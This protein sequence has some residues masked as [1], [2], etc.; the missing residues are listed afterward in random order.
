MQV[1]EVGEKWGLSVA[2]GQRCAVE[3]KLVPEGPV[4]QGAG[5]QVT[6]S[7]LQVRKDLLWLPGEGMEGKAL[8]RCH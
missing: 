5:G 2:G 7:E 3:V 6:E 1:I 4:G 8:R